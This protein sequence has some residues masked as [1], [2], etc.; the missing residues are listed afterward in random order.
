MPT[1]R[2]RSAGFVVGSV[3]AIAFGTVF[4]LV[5]SG[6]LPAPWPLVIRVIGLL[7][8][9]LLIGG[10]VHRASTTRLLPE[11]RVIGEVPA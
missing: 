8:A 9:A 1:G 6:G 11:A 4:V 2:Q 3:V 5:N 7:V 10:L